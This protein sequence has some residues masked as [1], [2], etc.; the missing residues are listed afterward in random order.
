MHYLV[1][2]QVYWVFGLCPSSGILKN[3]TFWKLDLFLSSGERVETPTLLGPLEL[4]S[5]TRPVGL[6]VKAY[7]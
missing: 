2:T 4:T 5:V 7:T 3:I 1:D 6:D